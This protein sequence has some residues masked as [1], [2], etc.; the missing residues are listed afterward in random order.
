MSDSPKVRARREILM[1]SGPEKLVPTP[2]A[3]AARRAQIGARLRIR[4]LPNAGASHKRMA[5]SGC[6]DVK[7]WGRKTPSP[8]TGA[9]A[10]N[11][12][13]G[14][15]PALRFEVKLPPRQ[16]HRSNGQTTRADKFFIVQIQP[17]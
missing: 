6:V 1:A 11:W 4:F 12:N 10:V 15:S 8:L 2:G 5:G 9:T 13:G 3:F 14:T 16:G 17:D 7:I